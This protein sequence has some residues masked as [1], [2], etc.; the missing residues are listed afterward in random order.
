MPVLCHFPVISDRDKGAGDADNRGSTT[1]DSVAV[2]VDW[3]LDFATFTSISAYSAYDLKSSGDTDLAATPALHRTRWEDYDQYSQ[4]L[5]LVSPG[6]E[7]IDWIAGAYYQRNELDISRRIDALDFLLEGAL[8]ADP[9]GL[10]GAPSQFDQ[11]S[12]SWSVF[13][14]GTWHYTDTLRFTLGARYSDETKDLDKVLGLRR[15]AVQT[16]RR[17][18]LCESA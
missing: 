16:W 18:L 14:S 17:Y 7:M 3:Q 2:T 4:E 15:P 11:D 1:T 10:P 8:Y 9:A 6:G 12:E 13:S 5:R